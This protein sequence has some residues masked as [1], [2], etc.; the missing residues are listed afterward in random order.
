[1]KSVKEVGFKKTFRFIIYTFLQVAYHHIISHLLLFP[2]ARKLFLILL[3]ATIGSNS[4]IM[5]V[6]F[7]NWHQGGPKGLKIGNECFIG[8]ETLI[9]LYDEVIL[10]NQ[11][12]LAQRVVVLTHLNVGY[13]DH[14]LQKY[15][16]KTSKKVIFK[17]GCVVGAASTILPGVIVG[18]ESFVGAGSVVTKDVPERTLVAGNP[19]KII[20]KI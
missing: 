14:P 19:A 1:M 15:F 12:T 6:G 5:D 20:R 2:Q 13:K 9:D 18:R 16:P 11:V 7:F 4:V 8:D 3:G 17:N 10:E